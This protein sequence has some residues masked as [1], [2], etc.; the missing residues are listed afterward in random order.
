MRTLQSLGA[1]VIGV[2]LVQE[3]VV[4][5]EID[6]W[7]KLPW[8]GV[9]VHYHEIGL[10][11]GNRRP[12]T[13]ALVKNLQRALSRFG[14][15]V[16]D[17]FDRLLVR[18]ETDRLV[19]ILFAAPKVFGVAY[20]APVRFLNRSIDAMV[21][22][23]I[24]TYTA[25]A[26]GKETFAVRVRRVDKSFPLTSHDLE[27][28]VGQQVAAATGAPVDLDEPNI[29]LSFRVYQDCIYQVGPKVQGV[30]GLPV[31]VTGKVLALISG[32]IDSPVAA[33]LT[34]KRGCFVDFVHFHAFPSN[35]EAVA[36]KVPKLVERLVV[37]QGVTCHLFLVPYHT[38]Q[39]ALLMSKVP[40][41]LELV[42]FRRFMVKVANQI[43]KEH[44]HKA[45]VTGDNLCQVAS[46]TLE[47][48]S[49]LD[50][51]SELPILR[52]LLTYDKREIITLAQQIGTYE[53]SI[54]PYKDCCSL[55]A[56]HP[57]TRAKLREVLEAESTL[58]IEQLVSRSLSEMAVVTIGDQLIE[59]LSRAGIKPCSNHSMGSN[60]SRF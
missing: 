51:A 37:P 10:K 59:G 4:P 44:G 54:Q 9:V 50:N 57:E 11:G 16:Q 35:D 52:P 3:K 29:L 6:K 41:K 39:L 32:G 34:M 30:G 60:Y 55:I 12:F 14:V 24:Q 40:Q 7:L 42:L 23:A 19:D 38:F 45:I 1:Q 43:A 26:L 5:P 15:E 25:L 13:K 20:A 53:L 18:A 17:L 22:A 48:L 46:Q 31:G 2:M 56:R 8:D 27:C 36:E 47:N 58:P 28:M 21:D 33:W 49:V